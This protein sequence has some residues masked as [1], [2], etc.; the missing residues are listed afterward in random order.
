MSDGA[1]SWRR[2]AMAGWGPP[3]DPQ[4]YGEFELDAR[5]LLAHIDAVR[6]DTGVHV[7]MTQFVG[8]AVA[9]AL[10]AVPKL[11]VRLVRGCLRARESVDVFFIVTTGEGDELTGIKVRDA[12]R[13]SAAEIAA[14]LQDRRSS[15]QAG[16]DPDLGRG[17]ALMARMLWWLLRHVLAISAWLTSDLNLDLR[18]ISLPRQAF[19]GAMVTSVGMWGITRA[20]SPLAAYYRVPLLVLVGAVRP[21]PVAEDSEVVR[22]P[23]T[24]VD[25]D[26]RPPLH[27]RL[28]RGAVRGRARRVLR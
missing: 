7:T 10:A 6:R 25:R 19:G 18:R 14:E 8:R 4:F 20:Y 23:G 13:K 9:H 16:V 22:T 5:P 21:Q 28:P 27:R 12:D 17:K 3:R 15:L 1:R 24:A 11:R 2:L 26:F